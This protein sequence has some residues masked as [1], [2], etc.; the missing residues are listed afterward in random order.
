MSQPPPRILPGSLKSL[1]LCGPAGPAQDQTMCHEPTRGVPTFAVREPVL[2]IK[3]GSVVETRTFTKPRD[4]YNPDKA[5][6]WPGEAE[7]LPHGKGLSR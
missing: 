5:G 7:G 3:P 2:R 4:Y 6:P 1:I